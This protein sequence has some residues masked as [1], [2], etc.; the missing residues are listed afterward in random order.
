M[1][2][3]VA[4][5]VVLALLGVGDRVAE[6]A[7]EGVL[8]GQLEGE[9]GTR[10]DV[11]VRG[12]P[13]LTQVVRGTYEEVRVSAGPVDAGR[14][15]LTSVDASLRGV[16]VPLR[17]AVSGAVSRVPVDRVVATAVLGYDELTALAG[18]R[19][20]TVSADPAGVRVAGTVRVLGQRLDAAAVSSVRLDGDRLAVTAQRVEVGGRSPSGPVADALVG[21]LD[22]DLPLP[23]LPY[24]LD[25]SSVSTTSRG[26]LLSGSVPDVVLRR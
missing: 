4:A 12:F 10:P 3:L 17:D 20:L 9:L 8:A 1:R 16:H 2:L 25:L 11:E 13:F 24:G 26:V 18:D 6:Q 21:A 22:L 23:R 7:A 19:G 14:L 15:A 5:V